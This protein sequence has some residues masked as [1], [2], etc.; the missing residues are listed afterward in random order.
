VADLSRDEI[1]WLNG[2]LAG[3]VARETVAEAPAAPATVSKITIAYGTETGNSKKL[4][5]AFAAKAKQ[6]K[7]QA[8]II[9]LEQYNCLTC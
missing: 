5:T 3:I 2:Y 8:K 9:A 7:I 1:I 6:A 4:A